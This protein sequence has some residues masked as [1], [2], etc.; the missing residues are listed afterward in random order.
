MTSHINGNVQSIAY[1]I[2]FK[3]P[4]M[5]SLICYS[6][7]IR[8][9]IEVTAFYVS[10]KSCVHYLVQCVHCSDIPQFMVVVN[11]WNTYLERRAKRVTLAWL[12]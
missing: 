8:R 6:P 11:K 1:T 7:Y 5:V 3:D 10:G 9:R 4:P 2:S 12:V